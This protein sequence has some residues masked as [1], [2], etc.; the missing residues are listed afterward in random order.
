M[1]T[2]GHVEVPLG[3]ANDEELE[4]A[5]RRKIRRPKCAAETQ[6]V[7]G[8]AFVTRLHEGSS[9]RLS[10]QTKGRENAAAGSVSVY[11]SS[12]CVLLNV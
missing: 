12:L 8:N 7:Q 9:D 3:A 5:P 11:G 10:N 4:D 6:N 1:T 2:H